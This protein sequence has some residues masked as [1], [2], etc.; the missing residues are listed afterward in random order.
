MKH[1]AQMSI[2]EVSALIQ[3]HAISPAELVEESIRITKRLQGTLNPYI[4]FLEE[5]ARKRAALLTERMPKD[6]SDRP[7]YG[8]PVGLK[9]LYYTKGIRTTGGCE[10]FA[11]FVPDHDS[12]VAARLE[13]AGAVLMGKQNTQE[14]ACGAAGDRSF[15][16]AMHNP[17]DPARISGGSSGGS[18]IAVA[19]GMN[20]LAMGTDSGGSIRI[21][22]S[23]CGV[24]GLKPSHGLISLRGVMPMS[25]TM[26]HAG[27]LTRSVLDAAIAL[28]AV[29]DRPAGYARSAADADRLDGIT[30]GVPENYFFEKTAEDVERLVREAIRCMEDLGAT[31]RPV[32]FAPMDDL[33]DVSFRLMIA[34]AAHSNRE[35][36]TAEK[37]LISEPIRDRLMRGFGV[38]AVSYLDARERR[39]QLIAEWDA[40]LREVDVVVCPT[41]P[42]T[43]FPLEG[44]RRVLLKGQ[45]EDG[46]QMCTHH[47]RHANLTGAPALSVPVGLVGNGMPAGMMIM[48]ARGDD[49]TVLRV[50]HAY[51]KAAPFTCPVF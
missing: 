26:D 4:T 47:T 5:E 42:L 17:Y 36:L 21:P 38:S 44:D 35:A 37:V 27:P 46:V 43:A 40:M 34:E 3:S 29:A 49:R 23:L 45:W 31:V 28:D 20:Y 18:A 24:V 51:E 15:F 41:L 25:E 33:P 39:R 22:A 7:L 11:S 48:G 50:G 30:V 13:A 14:L 32:R 10:H 2:S 12:D 8:L 19:T 1:L 16:G 9:D 6:L